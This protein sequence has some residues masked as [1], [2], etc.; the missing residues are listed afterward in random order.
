[1][2]SNN[3][4]YSRC[5]DIFTLHC[6]RSWSFYKTKVTRPRPR[7]ELQNQDQD[8]DQTCKTKTKTEA[9]KTKTKTRPV[10]V[11]LRPVLSQDRGLR[12]HHCFH[13]AKSLLF[14]TVHPCC[15]KGER[16]EKVQS[17]HNRKRTNTF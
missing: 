9:Y 1:M 5:F 2:H 10:F 13:H 3:A 4:V 6:S 17:K 15:L 7:S 11:G 14:I 12:P 16:K 8:Q